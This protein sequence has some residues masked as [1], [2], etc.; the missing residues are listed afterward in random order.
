MNN[1]LYQNYYDYLSEE[2]MTPFY[3][4]RLNNLNNLRL[5]DI[6]KRKNPYLFI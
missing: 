2:V 6:L 5:K 3:N 4:D 1:S